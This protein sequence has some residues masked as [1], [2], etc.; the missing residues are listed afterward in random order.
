MHVVQRNNS[1]NNERIEISKGKIQ[2]IYLPN[3][4]Y[5]I[6]VIIMIS[7]MSYNRFNRITNKQLLISEAN[8]S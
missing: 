8:D 6:H 5:P 2:V 7:I 3:P 4:T 1:N